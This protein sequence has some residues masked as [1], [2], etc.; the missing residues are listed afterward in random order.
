MLFQ[1]W[2]ITYHSWLTFVLLLWAN[3]LWIVPNQRRSMLRS[4]P[5]LVVYAI[6]LLLSGYLYSM[7]LTEEELPSEYQSVN[8]KQI[9]FEK[10]LELPCKQLFV[11]CAY[12]VMFWFTLRQYT[13][14]RREAKQSSAL[15][16]MVAPLQV[17][18]GTAAGG[19]PTETKPAE[20]SHTLNAIGRFLSK[21]LT[22]CWIWVVAIT[23][24]VVA[25]TGD[26]MTVFRILYMTLFLFFILTF[27]VR[28]LSPGR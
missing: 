6:F 9:G 23:L 22:R 12:T 4:S 3:L 28:D 15:A 18:V 19:L 14:E 13:K 8:L 27:Q 24:F 1:T 21:F 7:D 20:G 2:S 11:K 16:D 26:R 17:T 5:F 10:I 25:I